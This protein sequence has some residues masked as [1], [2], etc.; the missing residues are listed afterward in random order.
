MKRRIIVYSVFLGVLTILTCFGLFNL[1]LKTKYT[2]NE[3]TFRVKNDLAYFEANANYY[4]GEVTEPTQTYNAKYTQEDV[5]SGEETTI[6]PWDIG[7]SMFIYDAPNSEN[8]K[9]VLKYVITITNKNDE[10]NLSIK[11][12][13]V[14]CQ[15]GKLF[16]TEIK[17]D[18][19]VVFDNGATP[20]NLGNMFTVS[21]SSVSANI[22]KVI[23][24]DVSLN[25]EITLSLKTRTTPF[26][27]ENN[28]NFT[29]ESVER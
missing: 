19:V 26:N 7:E 12:G 3:I 17:F 27:T 28:I 18:N 5:Y 21:T 13:N 1:I 16:T 6:E 20:I 9:E 2:N 10:R 15:N 14:A 25:I 24:K 11:L 29:L 22:A 8:N 23:G 4:Y